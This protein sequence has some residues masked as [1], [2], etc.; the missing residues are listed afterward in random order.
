[1]LTEAE[2]S[3][4]FDGYANEPALSINIDDAARQAGESAIIEAMQCILSDRALDDAMRGELMV[5]PSESY[6]LEQVVQTGALADPGIIH[7]EREN[8]KAGIAAKLKPAMDALYERVRA[9]AYDDDGARGA[10]KVKT[11]ALS[12]LAS[13][14]PQSAAQLAK[15]QYDAADNMTDRQGALM[16]LC[17][18]E[19]DLEHVKALAKHADFSMS[20]PNRVRS[21]YM[22][23]AGNPPAF[24]AASGEGYRMI[25]DLII[26]LDKLNPQTAARFVPALGKWRKIVVARYIRTSDT[27]AGWV[28]RF[29]M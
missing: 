29:R 28:S 24:H 6:L 13:A 16:V 3:F 9:V 27:L 11:L 19:C 14:D 7:D 5:L 2:H 25:A 26:D 22:A 10:R 20:N 21:L 1:V 23:L 8:L 12:Y 17:G 18:L 4:T 15:S